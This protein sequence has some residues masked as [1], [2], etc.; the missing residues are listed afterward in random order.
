MVRGYF[1]LLSSG[2]LKA[3]APLVMRAKERSFDR[4]EEILDKVGIA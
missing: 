4:S 2:G 1:Q 3:L